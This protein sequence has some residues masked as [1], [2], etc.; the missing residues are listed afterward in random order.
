[1][2]NRLHQLVRAVPQWIGI[3][4]LAFVPLALK[5]QQGAFLFNYPGPNTIAVG[6][7]CTGVLQ[8]NIGTP[9]VS[10]FNMS[11]ITLSQINTTLTTF[12]LN[13]P[14]TPGL[15]VIH[16]DVANQGGQS[17]TFVF[18]ITFVDQSAPVFDLFGIDQF[19]TF[20]SIALVP[21]APNIPVIDNCTPVTTTYVQTTPPALCAGGVFTRTWTA[22]DT[23]SNTAVFTQTITIIADI[24]PPQVLVSPQNGSSPCANLPTAYPAWLSAQMAA[25]Q[26][27]DPSG[28]ASYTNNS[29]L[30][31]PPGCAGNT[32][33]TFRATDNCGLF[34]TRTATFFT[35]DTQPPVIADDA[36]D[37]VAFCAL[38]G[39]PLPA[40]SAWIQNHAT[41]VAS[42]ACTPTNNLV[43]S[44]QINGNTIDS[45][46]VVAAFQASFANGCGPQT[47]GGVSYNKVRGKVTVDFFVADAC[48]LITPAGQADFGAIDT[49][50]PIVTG[51]TITEQCG[52]NN[53][54]QVLANWINANGNATVTDECSGYTWTNFSWTTSLGVT[55]NGVFNTGPYPV[56]P[57]NN[58]N[59]HVDVTFRVTD[60]CGNIGS[61]ILRFEI[62]DTIKPV[63]SGLAPVAI[64][65]CPAPLPVLPNAVVSDNCDNAVSIGYTRDTLQVV[66]DGSYDLQ[67]VWTATDDCGNSQSAVQILQVRDTT[68]PF[69]TL[70]PPTILLTCDNVVIP[71]PPTLGNGINASDACGSVT[72]LL[73]AITSQQNPDTSNCGHYTYNILRTFT[74]VDACGNTKT[75]VQIIAV[76]DL[77]PPVFSGFTSITANCE[78]TPVFPP[79]TATDICSGPTPTPVLVSD[80]ITGG[81]CDDSYIQT[82]TYNA[83]D[84]CGNVG[85]FIRQIF[86]VDTLRP[87]LIGIPGDLFVD[88]DGIPAPPGPGL[89]TGADNCDETVSIVMVQSE[90]RNPDTTLC[91]HWANYMIIRTWTVSDNCGNT[92]S[93]TQ[94][95]SVQDNTG[96]YLEIPDTISLPNETG[97]CGANVL[98]PPPISLYDLCSSVQRS[99]LLADTVVLVASGVPADL[100]PVNT[101]VFQWTVPGGPPL[102]P[103]TGTPLFTVFLDNADS[104]LASESFTIL[105]EDDVVLGITNPT[106]APC[107]NGSTQVNIPSNLLN[108]WLTDGE[109]VLRLAPN[110]QGADACNAICAGGRARGVL[111]YNQADQQV[112]IVL[113]YSL[114][115]GAMTNY[116]PPASVFLDAG[117]HQVSYLATDCAG[118]STTASL[119][120]NI[121]D[122]EPPA[123][124]ALPNLTAYVGAVACSA[125]VSLP[126]P[127]ITDNC[128][129]SGAIS[130]ASASVMVKFQSNPNIAGPVPT[131]TF[132]SVTGLIPNAVGNGVLRILNLGDN[133]ETGEFFRI[134]DESNQLLGTTAIGSLVG[135]CTAVNQ[136]IIAISANDIN[137]WAAGNGVSNFEARANT[138]VLNFSNFVSPC[139]PLTNQMD[140]ISTLQAVLEY[141]YAV[142]TYEILQ[143]NTVI[144]SALLTGAQTTVNL[145]PGVYS[146]RYTV[147]DASG[148]EG[149]VSF[150]LTVRDA[151]PPQALCVSTTI[152]TNPSGVVNY[153][154]LPSEINNGSSDQCSPTVGLQITPSIFN[155]NMAV[156]PQ[157]PYTVTLTVTDSSGNSATCTALVRVE[158]QTFQPAAS[159][160]VCEGGTIQLMAN[161]P[162]AP[163]NNAYTYKWSGPGN[164]MSTL[165][166]PVLT[167]VNLT[168]EGTYT[169]TITGFTG[170]TALGMVQV[171]L[172]TLPMPPISANTVTPCEGNSFL[173]STPPFVGAGVTYQ[174]FSGSPGSSTLL[175]NTV[176]PQYNVP[177]PPLGSN[178]YYVQTLGNGCSSEPSILLNVVVQARPPAVV[179]QTVISVCAG[180]NISFGTPLTGYNYSWTGPNGYNSLLQYPPSIV[181]A[182][183]IHAGVY[184]LITSQN[185]CNSLPATVTVTINPRP[186]KP[187]LSGTPSVCEGD[188][189]KLICSF[190]PTTGQYFWVSPQLVTTST[191]INELVLP[192]VSVLDS[193]LWNVYIIQGGCQSETS[194]SFLLDVDK[195][196]AITAS[197]NAPLCQGNLLQLNAAANM[198][199][200]FYSWNGP[201]GFLSLQQNPTTNGVTGV[202][203]VVAQTGNGCKDTSS[204]NVL[205]I[206]LPVVTVTNN[207]LPCANGSQ[208]VQLQPT[209][210]TPYSPVTY[211]WMGPGGFV[212]SLPMPIIPGVDVDDNGTYVVVV[213]DAFGCM[214]LPGSTTINVE[215]NPIQP[216]ITSPD[217]I[218]CVGEST[219]LQVPTVY[220]Q[221][222]DYLWSTPLG[223]LILTNTPFFVINNASL[224]QGGT[225]TVVVETENC[226]S[227][228]S[229]AFTVQVLAAPAQP[230]AFVSSDSVC[231]GSPLQLSTALVA[232]ATYQWEGPCFYSSSLQNPLINPTGSCTAGAYSVAVT[233]NGCTSPESETVLVALKPVPPT[234]VALP[235]TN[236]CLDSGDTLFLRINN[237][238]ALPF[239]QY[240]WYNA[241]NNQLMGPS[242]IA[243]TYPVT[244]LTSLLP[245]LNSFYV[246][247]TLN[248]CN[249]APSLPVQ[250]S[251]DTVPNNNAYA[252]DD[253][254]AC[255]SNPITLDA[256]LPGGSVT[257]RWV[258]VSGPLVNIVNPANPGT[259]ITGAL[260]GNTYQFAWI[261]SNG[262]CKNY[263]NDI[264]AVAV[265]AAEKAQSVPFI[266][267]CAETT[268]TLAATQGQSAPGIWTQPNGQQ[269]LGVIIEDPF[270]PNTM[271][272]GMTP[273]NTYLFY[274][275]LPNLGCGVSLDTTRVR[276]LSPKPNAGSDIS[277]CS[278]DNCTILNAETIPSSETSLWSSN[279]PQLSFTN[280]NNLSTTVC[281]LE[282]GA[283]LI[284]FTTNDGRCG[285]KSRDTLTINFEPAPIAVADTVYVP[286][287]TKKTMD[288]LLN[289]FLPDAYSVTVVEQP[290]HG[291]LQDM[292][293]GIY[294]YLPNI[295]YDGQDQFRYKVCNLNCS[296]AC[297]FAVVT[298]IVEEQGDCAIPTLFT[299]NNDGVND[300]FVVPC[301]GT[302]GRLD[303]EV[304]I[305]NQWGDEVFGAQPYNNNWDGTYNGEDLP[306]G[307]YYYVVKFNAD[308]GIK[309]GFLVLQR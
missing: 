244:N 80:V 136:T 225:Y 218:I 192:I 237:T 56:V 234:P 13:D 292:T 257:G 38:S 235:A 187:L 224:L 174:W 254:I 290:V 84:V 186:A 75:A 32:V 291:I 20:G 214:S 132:L 81:S 176:I 118:N 147:P 260:A 256:D 17:A 39:P 142:V 104:E 272:L 241:Q 258:L 248:G 212:S 191:S 95:I 60:D 82:L 278:A 72:G 76:Q 21:P 207:A 43:W 286:N 177:A 162:A 54:N 15:Y 109:L 79:P 304:S 117:E 11:P 97:L 62:R 105:G 1:M 151:V 302:D 296:D 138:D 185:G 284:V 140:G 247:A 215:N 189:A 49:I 5:A 210:V 101:V 8:G 283:N 6:V 67:V 190:P 120:L 166:N 299:P 170:C 233:V 149:S 155:C 125:T 53:D 289:D 90:I 30:P 99:V 143:N 206:P 18:V 160:G 45:A 73:S 175:A 216:F 199:G 16:W 122:I 203:T 26:A 158:T 57:A 52:Q 222:V 226:E 154:L 197:Y 300:I 106:V 51:T 303:N 68:S 262:A 245:G 145:P 4:L 180:A 168:A 156:G 279:N 287:A 240:T 108:L 306:A 229:A 71:P 133:G 63:F 255:A 193:G 83:T 36:N 2:I 148:T 78:T 47:I 301:L 250:V 44:M 195:K 282:P 77:A 35:S 124:A 150:G 107:G 100:V 161:P 275:A 141:P 184:T 211:S 297:T 112:P 263:S 58:C 153:T 201:S 40:L 152:F 205:L 220:N 129:V 111:Q 48:G 219:I 87:Q 209:V 91:E 217:A 33:V 114:D 267:I 268:V 270:D 285:D 261:L 23:F 25:F 159:S 89:I 19:L 265:V 113:M 269:L 31:Y 42:D 213:T 259:T 22:T 14:Q 55:G 309:T 64:H 204:V 92:R 37:V 119:L 126:F 273:G 230:V 169:V 183:A 59:W 144:Q 65:Y 123:M 288:V 74:A 252:G 280:P 157:N 134:F 94:S 202:Y 251:F 93:Y 232:G 7:N 274:W 281:G 9:V 208:D 127:D 85:V 29:P 139:G 3:F 200:L 172:V 308:G 171:D 249:S 266:E 198:S 253:F 165:A 34:T 227:L 293:D 163:G 61:G 196:P 228:P 46:G 236:V 194:L 181:N 135:Q 238:P 88:C 24:L 246:V 305:F 178:T 96:P 307:T 164:Y 103:V 231:A 242:T 98:V 116:P 264:V 298:L 66:C 239:A 110:S 276:S 28:I 137:Q 69:F 50:R 243:L 121:D 271:V 173:L 182:S 295:T 294:S 86:F 10:S 131:N 179:D 130:K 128:G 12:G 41:T 167:N 115:G 188:T 221:D 27:S 277:I 102:N 223:E 146:V 70:F